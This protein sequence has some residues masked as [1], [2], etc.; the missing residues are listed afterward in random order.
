MMDLGIGDGILSSTDIP[1]VLER[2]GWDFGQVASAWRVS[3]EPLQWDSWSYGSLDYLGGKNTLSKV[4][5]VLREEKLT[6]KVKR[7]LEIDSSPQQVKL[8]R[9]DLPSAKVLSLMAQSSINTEPVAAP[10]SKTVESQSVDNKACLSNVPIPSFSTPEVDKQQF[11]APEKKISTRAKLLKQ[12]RQ[13]EARRREEA[14]Q[15]K[16]T[17]WLRWSAKREEERRIEKAQLASMRRKKEDSRISPSL[18]SPIYNIPFTPSPVAKK[19]L[20]L[21]PASPSLQLPTS[22]DPV[23]L[24]FPT[25]S[26]S[27]KKDV[28]KNTAKMLFMKEKCASPSSAVES[29]GCRCPESP[30]LKKTEESKPNCPQNVLPDSCC[31]GPRGST[32]DIGLLSNEKKKDESL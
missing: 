18:L 3:S 22:P 28:L 1:G 25:L 19:I 9:F 13:E 2:K 6:G 4:W 21:E 12:K 30:N 31:G 5:S 8:P 16:I 17:D 15:K 10:P 7:K 23:D 24:P 14:N 27:L 20:Q 29:L 32:A 11:A 26:S